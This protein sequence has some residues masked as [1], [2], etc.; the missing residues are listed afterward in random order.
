[1]LNLSPAAQAFWGDAIR[2]VL[3]LIAAALVTHGV[4]SQGVATAY[5]QEL[6]GVILAAGVTVWGNRAVYWAQI[7]AIVGRSLPSSAT[8]VTVVEKVA[9]LQAA[10]ALPS[11]FTPDTVVPSLVKPNLGGVK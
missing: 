4:V 7:R 11:V 10:S 6:V 5:V 3:T 1:M 2:R 9:Q 8:H